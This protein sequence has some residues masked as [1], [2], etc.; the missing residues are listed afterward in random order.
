MISR[1][2]GR[3][4]RAAG[5]SSASRAD[6]SPRRAAR[7]RDASLGVVPTFGLLRQ[8]GEVE[9]EV[10]KG[11][12]LVRHHVFVARDAVACGADDPDRLRELLDRALF[13]IDS[14]TGE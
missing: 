8:L 11:M 12:A 9:C 1:G 6:R 4:A 10:R 3:V 14:M 7:A 13:A 5:A 2:G